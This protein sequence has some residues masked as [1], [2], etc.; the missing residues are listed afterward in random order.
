MR[1]S[2]SIGVVQR[3]PYVDEECAWNHPGRHYEWEEPRFP[4]VA[5]VQAQ[6]GRGASIGKGKRVHFGY[7]KSSWGKKG[8]KQGYEQGGFKGKGKGKGKPQ[9]LGQCHDC[10]DWARS[11]SR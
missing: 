9:F 3:G 11:Q 2:T 6:W 8:G 10:G 7:G 1:W 5:Q 4:Q